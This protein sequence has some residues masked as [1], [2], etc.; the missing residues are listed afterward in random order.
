MNCIVH[1]MSFLNDSLLKAIIFPVEHCH[2]IS[3]SNS[4]S[5]PCRSFYEG[6]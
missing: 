2:L 6:N 3:G 1:G 5:F 4:L